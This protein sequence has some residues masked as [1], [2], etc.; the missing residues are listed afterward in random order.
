MQPMAKPNKSRFRD[1]RRFERITL[2]PK[3]IQTEEVMELNVSE[4]GNRIRSTA[5][6]I[7]AFYCKCVWRW[8]LLNSMLLLH[9]QLHSQ[10]YLYNFQIKCCLTFRCLICVKVAQKCEQSQLQQ[11]NLA[12]RSLK[13]I[14]KKA[15]NITQ[16]GVFSSAL[17]IRPLLFSKMENNYETSQLDFTSFR[18]I[19]KDLELCV[20][21]YFHS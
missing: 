20:R 10:A 8:S 16:P 21:V 9:H 18:P 1:E 15:W 4:A 19:T 17:P 3:A 14:D 5:G 2:P 12:P 6:A 11:P 13:V 7:C